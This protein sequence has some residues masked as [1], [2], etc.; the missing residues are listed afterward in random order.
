MKI[1]LEKDH[2]KKLEKEQMEK[3]LQI[4][5]QKLKNFRVSKNVNISLKRYCKNERSENGRKNN[6]SLSDQN[7]NRLV[8]KKEVV[9]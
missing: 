8:K 3:R 1:D 7:A 2:K 4:K 6:N 9:M 5:L